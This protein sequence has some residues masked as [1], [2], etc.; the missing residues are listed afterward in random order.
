MGGILWLYQ[1][2]GLFIIRAPDTDA[3]ENSLGDTSWTAGHE[4][5]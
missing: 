3:T 1:P 2:Q 5:K 4:K